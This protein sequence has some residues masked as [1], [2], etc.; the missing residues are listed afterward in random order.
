M[1]DPEDPED[2]DRSLF[3]DAKHHRAVAKVLEQVEKGHIPRL[4]VTFPQVLKYYGLVEAARMVKY[5]GPT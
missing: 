3:K 5:Y 4:I 1:P 2:L